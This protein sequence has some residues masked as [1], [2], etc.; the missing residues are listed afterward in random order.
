MGDSLTVRVDELTL[1][2][3][4]TDN[5]KIEFLGGWDPAPVTF[6]IPDPLFRAH[7]EIMKMREELRY[8]EKALL[9]LQ[10][11]EISGVVEPLVAPGEGVYRSASGADTRFTTRPELGDVTIRELPL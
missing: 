8:D 9:P 6:P 1:V 7:P 3:P 4:V 5:T 2:V 10:A 11:L